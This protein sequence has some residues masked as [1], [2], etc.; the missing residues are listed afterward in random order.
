MSS[1]LRVLRHHNFR[2]L[3]LGQA[4]SVVG[5]QV[6]IVA[7]ALFVTQR[8][9]SP[10]DLGMVLGAQSLMLV[11]LLLFGGVWADRLA[12]Q[13]IM[14]TADAA[15]GVLQA[16]L[17]ILIF[18]GSV[19]VW[20]MVVI[21]AAYG[22]FQAFFQ[23]AYSGLVP[24]TVP[25]EL[26]QDAKAL[27]E[28]VSNVAFM[29]GPALG[30]ALVLGIGAGEA[31]AFDALT[32]ALSVLF[33]LR[34]RPGPAAG[35]H[36]VPARE[37]M[38]H[39]LRAGYREVRSRT[40]VWVVIVVFMGTLL[41][42][43]AQWYSLAPRI[44]RDVYGSAGVFGALESVSGAGAVV[45]ALIGLRWRP[46]RPLMTGM[47]L[48]LAW[49][50]QNG[51]FAL[52][53]PLGIV[54]PCAF[55]TGFG[56]SLLIIWWETALAHH[57]PPN[58]LS[59]VSAW[60][61]MGSTAL[62]PL[63]FFIAGPL[64]SFFGARNV[65][66]VG[67]MIGLVLLALSIAPRSVRTLNGTASGERV[68]RAGDDEQD[69]DQSGERL[70]RHQG[71]GPGAQRQRVGGAERGGIGVGGVEVI[72]EARAPAGGQWRLGHLREQEVRGRAAHAHAQA[73]P[74]AAAVELPVPDPE[75]QDVGQPQDGAG[76]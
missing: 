1:Y 22:G 57:I 73:T 74:G 20:E 5:D 14:I 25:G 55:A 59:R 65:L 75:D 39:E 61:W 41:C 26:I 28:S 6:V 60:D 10:T 34:V 46:A 67:C 29:V 3:F 13:R 52:G 71:L 68:D 2:C 45:G 63:G 43:Y 31:F 24:Q 9:G 51:L 27:T 32:F 8:T 66:G 11:C 12:R 70:D 53:T 17:A 56:F 15:R 36:D 76:K 62:L 49:P 33:L 64:A 47:L 16:L 30:T 69:G 7:L 50:V 4:A 58:A 21:A 35:A 18:T 40:W 23:P 48:L 19:R 72:D 44:A 38:L 54:V 37:S 42:V